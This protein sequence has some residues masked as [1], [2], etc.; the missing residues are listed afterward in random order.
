MGGYYIIFMS[1]LRASFAQDF[2]WGTSTSAYQIEGGGSN[3]DWWRFERAVG[4][5]AVE[6][7]GVACDSWN[8]Y[9][10]DLDIAASLGLNAFRLSVEWA[11]VEPH[12]GEID[13]AVLEHYGR[14]LDAC[15][16]RGLAPVVT[17]HHFTLPLWVADA[18]G[19]E[20]PDIVNSIA[21][22]ARVVAEALG[23][24]IAFACTINE[25]NIVAQM[26]YLYGFFPP[27]VTD[28]A[29]FRAVNE[30]LR[31]AHRAM[32]D[33]LRAG[34]GSYP[35]G[36]ALSMAQYVSV[37]GGEE[38]LASL[39]REMEDE[40][41]KVVQ[42]DDFLGVQCYTRHDIGPEGMVWDFEGERTSMGYRYWP[43]C[44]EYTLHRAA[45]MTAI[46]LVVTENGIGTEDD[47]QRIRYLAEALEGL[48]RARRGG[49]DVRGY[50]QWSLL[51]NFEWTLG[52]GPKFGVVSVDRNTMTRSLKPSAD[53][54]ARY[55]RHGPSPTANGEGS[56]RRPGPTLPE[57]T[58]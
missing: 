8:R 27:A 42:D 14:V 48:R 35:V 4:T 23:E 55:V 39:R 50:F 11:R 45:Q 31:L 30:T 32:V 36:L 22:Y 34:P 19:F 17:F 13:V 25:P 53:W 29:R 40:Y 10:E 57:L 41:L 3:T 1:G 49:V 37:N 52:Y 24:K 44:V 5:P 56:R 16:A 6:T 58:D 18:G 2:Y 7:C 47:T 9:E 21:H 12:R 54:Y 20:S 33:A 43:Q 28:W 46:P 51:D 26:G 38:R 15:W